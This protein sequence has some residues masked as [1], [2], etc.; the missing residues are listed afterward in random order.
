M[1]AKPETKPETKQRNKYA[2]NLKNKDGLDSKWQHAG[3]TQVDDGSGKGTMVRACAKGGVRVLANCITG[4]MVPR[5][6][7]SNKCN[8][9]QLAVFF[10]T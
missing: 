3:N 10:S 7:Y 8:P 6:Q 2:L 4:K 5:K 9:C 1:D